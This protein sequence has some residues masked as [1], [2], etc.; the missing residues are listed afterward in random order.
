MNSYE[1][2]ITNM[3]DDTEMNA[4]Q[5][6]LYAAGVTD[7]G[8]EEVGMYLHDNKARSVFVEP[9]DVVK[10]VKVLNALGYETDE[11]EQDEE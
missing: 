8:D 3:T 5:S 1:I 9:L 4:V 2:T 10:A 6:A 11:D 7:A